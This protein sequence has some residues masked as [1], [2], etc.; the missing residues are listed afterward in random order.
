MKQVIEIL[1]ADLTG[2]WS[3]GEYT[4]GH[5]APP[6]DEIAKRAY[7]F[8]ETRGRQGGSALD[9]WLLAEQELRRHYA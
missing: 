3:I 5:S 9:D 2:E 4:G 7:Q 1:A 6:H 8:Y